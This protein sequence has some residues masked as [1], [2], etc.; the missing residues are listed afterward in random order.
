MMA[1]VSPRDSQEANAPIESASNRE[2]RERSRPLKP[3]LIK[4]EVR[5]SKDFVDF[6]V[7]EFAP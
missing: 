6:Y 5:P 7:A 1:D 2:T 4:P 3:T